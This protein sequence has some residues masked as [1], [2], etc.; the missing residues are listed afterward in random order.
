MCEVLDLSSCECTEPELSCDVCCQLANGTC[1]STIRI[2][3]E[4]T[5]G[6]GDMLPD[7]MGRAQLVGF[8][9]GNF[10]GYCDFFNNCMPVDSEG[11]LDRLLNFFSPESIN[12]AID[13]LRRMWWVVVIAGV[14]I[15]VG[16]FFVVLIVHK[17]LPRPEHVKRRAERRKSLRRSYKRGNRA[18]ALVTTGHELQNPNFVGQ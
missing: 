5:D 3:E 9:C 13:W 1:A 18:G 12:A 10:T 8:P 16:L 11:A 17:L 2:A 6:L 7:G 15:I 4:N 14:G